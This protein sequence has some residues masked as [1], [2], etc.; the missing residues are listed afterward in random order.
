MVQLRRH[1]D[2]EVELDAVPAILAAR[3]SQQL[4]LYV[5]IGQL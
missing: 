1:R 2:L 3:D 5:G 4:R